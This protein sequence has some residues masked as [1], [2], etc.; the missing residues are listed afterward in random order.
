MRASVLVSA[1]ARKCL[2]A[3]EEERLFVSVC[4]CA[5]FVIALIFAGAIDI[6]RRSSTVCFSGDAD[7]SKSSQHKKWELRLTMSPGNPFE[8]SHLPSFDALPA[9]F[10]ED[11]AVPCKR[12][13][14]SPVSPSR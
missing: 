3:S 7:P 6:A 1:C 13:A 2:Y 10:A 8:Q 4:V 14:L 11:L 9:S 5:A 12:F